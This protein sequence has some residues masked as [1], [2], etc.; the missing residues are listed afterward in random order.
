[1]VLDLAIPAGGRLR[2]EVLRGHNAFVAVA[3]GTAVID[4]RELVADTLGVLGVGDV[5][6]MSARENSRVLLFAGA[7]IGEPVARRGPFVMNTDEEIRQAFD[8]YRS[9]RLVGG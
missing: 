7:P 5:V 1:M 6:E 2:H 8:D 9:G 3:S 4:G